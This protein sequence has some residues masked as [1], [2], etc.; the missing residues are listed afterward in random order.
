MALAKATFIYH[1]Y[2]ITRTDLDTINI[3][4]AEFLLGDPYEDTAAGHWLFGTDS[5]S[6]VSRQSADTLTLQNTAPTYFANYLATAG[7]GNAL[8]TPYDDALAQTMCI[9]IQRPATG[10]NKMICGAFRDESQGSGIYQTGAGSTTGPNMRSWDHSAISISWPVGLDVG[11][12]C[13]LALSEDY[14]TAKNVIAY[15]GGQTAVETTY[16]TSKTLAAGGETKIPIGNAYFNT[17]SAQTDVNVAE[18][19]YFTS[20]LNTAAIDAV[21]TRSKERMLNRGITLF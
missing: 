5:G 19:I 2:N 1:P 21:Y 6:L 16:G 14:P 13:F 11:E 15:I 8:L 20:A 10:G 9:V 17:Y 3:D 18:F 7:F 12:W 4:D